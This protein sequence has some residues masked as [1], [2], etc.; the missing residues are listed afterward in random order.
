MFADGADGDGTFVDVDLIGFQ[1]FGLALGGINNADQLG[2][3]V[4]EL[5]E[6]RAGPRR[7]PAFAAGVVIV[8]D[9]GAT[10]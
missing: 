5:L 1:Q 9:S 7:H 4:L 2:I 8:A 10:D 6:H 3:G